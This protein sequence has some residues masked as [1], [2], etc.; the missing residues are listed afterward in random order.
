M[1]FYAVVAGLRIIQLKLHQR[2]KHDNV[3]KRVVADAYHISINPNF[4]RQRQQKN[5]Q[6]I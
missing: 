5:E 3:C 1:T 4:V 6:N 2:D